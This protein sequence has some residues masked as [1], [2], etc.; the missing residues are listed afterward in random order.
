MLRNICYWLWGLLFPPCCEVCGEPIDLTKRGMCLNCRL[1]MPL[2]YY[3]LRADNPT[4]QHI[5]DHVRVEQASS[6]ILFTE[7][8][9]WRT[10][11]H[12]F[13]YGGKWRL[14]YDIGKM[15]GMSLA[16][17]A[18]YRDVECVVPIPLHYR[19]HLHRGYNQSQYIADGIAE[20]MGIEVVADAIRRVRN[21]PSQALRRAQDRWDN[22]EGIFKLTKPDKLRNRH[23]LLVDDVLTTGATLVSCIAAIR[24]ALPDCRISVATLAVSDKIIRR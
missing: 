4:R 1:N 19:K 16:E 20:S 5:E 8:S 2:T 13:K 3:W 12:R 15:Y 10:L 18:L 7:G 24:K 6:Y 14:G 9:P 17:S 21:N 11:I 22:V 23:I